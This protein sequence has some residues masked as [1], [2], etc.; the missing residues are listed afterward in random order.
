MEWSTFQ[1]QGS[2]NENRDTVLCSLRNKIK[3]HYCSKAHA[4]AENIENLKKKDV[5]GKN[6]DTMNL[7]LLKETYSVFRTAYYLAKN[8]RPF[9]DHETL[10]ELQQLNG[11]K[12]G[13][14]LHSRF[15]ATNIIESIAKEMQCSIVNNIIRSSSKLAV[16]ID[17]ASTL[18]RRTTLIVNIKTSVLGEPP[19][20]IFLD[21]VE[22]KD[23]TSEGITDALMSCLTKAGFTEE[24]L[25][26]NWV[27]FVSD[28]ASVMLGKHSGVSTKLKMRFPNLLTWHCMNHRLELA[29]SD[30]VDK[31][32][33]INHFR[34]FVEKLHNIY[35]KSNKNQRELLESAAE[36]GSQVLKIG[37]ILDVRWVASSFRT[38]RAVWTSFTAL[39]RHFEK[40]SNDDQRTCTE[41]QTYRGLCDRLKSPEFLC[42]LGLMY[43]TLHELSIVSEELQAQTMTLLRADLLV[44]RAI[45]V[46]T[47]FKTQPGEKLSAALEAK[48]HGTFKDV[49]LK[50]N[51][52]MKSINTEE[53][54]Q[55]LIDSLQKRLPFEE[56]ILKD[57]SILDTSRWP[58]E[59]SIRYGE[60]EICRLCARF[61]VCPDQ[62]IKGMRDLIESPQTESQNLKPLKNCMQ[63]FPVS[64]A[65]CERG[66]SLMNTILTNKRSLLLVSHVSNLMMINLNGPPISLFNPEKYVNSWARHHRTA[67][68]PQSR[69]CKSVNI[70]KNSKSVWNV[71]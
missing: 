70:T 6:V 15:S 21:L 9:T 68:D 61:N 35:S 58:S 5:L 34:V 52:K 49:H 20:F 28:G 32:T 45:R 2:I 64:T 19:E 53:F 60:T 10:V 55:R 44:K 7:S 22:L 62:A 30:A 17:E 43:D 51:P 57:L 18:S 71:L 50:S 37:R 27:S 14:I 3:R 23:Q 63:T 42:D 40:A 26:Q 48:D 67:N 47:S 66:F 1:I 65:E 41:R 29:V 59:P 56:D 25:K 33:A 39:A 36:V 46:L 13:H 16:L 24:W 11:V 8:N 31:V 4:H 69:Q 38:V 12:M 54:L